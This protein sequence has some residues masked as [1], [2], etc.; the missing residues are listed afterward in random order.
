M[1]TA[2]W[3]L[4]SVGMIVHAVFT[5]FYLYWRLRWIDMPMHFLGGLWLGLAGIYIYKKIFPRTFYRKNNLCVLATALTTALLVGG[6]W[7]IIELN[8]TSTPCIARINSVMDTLSD[9]FCDLLG[10]CIGAILF[11]LLRQKH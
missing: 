4:L 7:E 8:L 9:L 1:P 6:L 2:M 10:A 5:H 3:I 11:I